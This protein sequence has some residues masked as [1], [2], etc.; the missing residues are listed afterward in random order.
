MTKLWAVH[1]I[2]VWGTVHP[3]LVRLKPL[4]LLDQFVRKSFAV[5]FQLFPINCI[6]FNFGLDKVLNS[7]EISAWRTFYLS[8]LVFDF[9]KFQIRIL[10]ERSKR[11]LGLVNGR[12]LNSVVKVSVTRFSRISYVEKMLDI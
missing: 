12:V 10:K 6:G 3:A 5:S 7:P 8:R 11:H 2:Q 4:P 9:D 1:T